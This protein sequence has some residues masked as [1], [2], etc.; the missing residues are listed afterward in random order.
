[1]QISTSPYTTTGSL[2]WLQDAW[3]ELGVV[4]HGRAQRWLWV[5]MTVDK[6]GGSSR[7]LELL[8]STR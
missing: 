5:E 4:V 1:M 6:Q 2:G 7:G 3:K 8:F